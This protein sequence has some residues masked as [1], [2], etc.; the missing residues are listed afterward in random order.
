MTHVLNIHNFANLNV[1]LSITRNIMLM[2]I[3]RKKR[4]NEAMEKSVQLEK[5]EPPI[6]NSV[7]SCQNPITWMTWRNF[8][9]PRGPALIPKTTLWYYIEVTTK[10]KWLYNI[11]VI[12]LHVIPAMI[13]DS[14]GRLGGHKPR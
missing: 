7:S 12:F 5:A 9:V 14:V 4:S 8:N 6:Y 10:R 13:I 11:C 2:I 1:V 3:F